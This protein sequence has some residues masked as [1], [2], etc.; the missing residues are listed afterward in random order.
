MP[1]AAR[2]SAKRATSSLSRLLWE[3]KTLGIPSSAYRIPSSVKSSGRP[4]D[5][6]TD[7]PAWTT[8]AGEGAGGEITTPKSFRSSPPQPAC[9]ALSRDRH[10]RHEDP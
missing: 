7:L 5:W 4:Y 1:S 8:A 9:P 6:E 10:G 3:R 2:S